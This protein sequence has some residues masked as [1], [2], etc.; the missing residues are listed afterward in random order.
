MSDDHF[1]DV[2][3]EGGW[4]RAA[5]DR[6]DGA[7]R[8][9]RSMRRTSLWRRI[10]EKIVDLGLASIPNAGNHATREFHPYGANGTEVRVILHV[11]VRERRYLRQNT[12]DLLSN[13]PLRL[14]EAS[15]SWQALEVTRSDRNRER[16]QGSPVP[17]PAPWPYPRDR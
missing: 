1:H 7:G 6:T 2:V 4:E 3:R 11:L 12:L 9:G 14:L 15:S 17:R 16:Q 8:A 10:A 5:R 13:P